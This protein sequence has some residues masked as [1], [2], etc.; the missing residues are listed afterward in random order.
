VGKAHVTG[1]GEG[2]SYTYNRTHSGEAS[3]CA[4]HSYRTSFWTTLF[5]FYFLNTGI[6][7][8][9]SRERRREGMEIMP[10]TEMGM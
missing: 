1:D 8:R 2:R 7:G 6:K 4:P 10:C 9:K 5:L 3:Y